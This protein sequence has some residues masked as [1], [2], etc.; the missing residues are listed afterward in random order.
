MYI[1]HPP[2][3]EEF[4]VVVNEAIATCINFTIFAI[5]MSKHSNMLIIWYVVLFN[6]YF[7]QLKDGR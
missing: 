4:E 5:A 6:E 3:K 1:H 2:T 7:K